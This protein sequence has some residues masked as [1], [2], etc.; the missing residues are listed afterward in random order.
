MPQ[1]FRWPVLAFLF[2]KSMYEAIFIYV[3]VYICV[4]VYKVSGYTAVETVCI[5]IKALKTC[6]SEMDRMT[7]QLLQQIKLC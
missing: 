6:S 4:S 1:K 7:I 2:L 3:Y 5:L